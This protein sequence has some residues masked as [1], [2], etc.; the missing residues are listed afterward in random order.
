M[1]RSPEP[2][3]SAPEIRLLGPELDQ[4]LGDFFGALKK[5]NAD[6]FFHPHALTSEEARRLC[7]YTGKDLYYVL[8]DEGQVLAYGMLRGWDEGFD[9]PSLGIATLSSARGARLSSLL[10]QFLHAVA[11]RRG[12]RKVIL[13]VYKENAAARKLYEGL[14][15]AFTDMGTRQLLGSIDL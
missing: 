6:A 2:T 1:P 8:I 7:R 11:R 9:I 10:A 14:G 15:Y 5:E 4:A 12:A 13:K 3:S